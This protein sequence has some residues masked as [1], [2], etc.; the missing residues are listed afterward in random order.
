MIFTKLLFKLPKAAIVLLLFAGVGTLN[1]QAQNEQVRFDRRESS[2]GKIMHAIESQTNMKFAYS[3]ATYDTTRMVSLPAT[4]LTVKEVL[5]AM[6]A[7]KDVKY[8]VQGRYIA[9]V[10]ATVTDRPQVHKFTQRTSD[11]YT[12][13]NNQGDA[14]PVVR[15]IQPPVEQAK[16]IVAELPSTQPTYPASYSDYTSLNRY[17]QLQTSLPRFAIKTNLL[18]GG[19]A[20]APNLAFEFATGPK[21]TIEI[22]GSYNGWYRDENK[23]DDTKQLVHSIFRGEYRWWTCERYN[24]HFFGAHAFYTRYH[25]S[26]KDVP[27][28]FDKENRYNGYGVGIGATYGYNLPLGNRW[29]L[30]F[31]VGVGAAYLKYDKY[32]CAACDREA[33]KT[34]K[35]YFGP[36]R[37]GITLQFLIK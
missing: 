31:N 27:L 25:V 15:P 17:S 8:V 24:G 26:A 28:L 3:Y 6:V 32:T 11:V 4:T 12:P 18:Y 35:W 7:D 29:G 16:P 30:E 36:T 21:Q 34:D 2:G 14:S 19:V 5:E 23:P 10:P 1:A 20:L 13:S 9:F 37:L 33:V 22:S